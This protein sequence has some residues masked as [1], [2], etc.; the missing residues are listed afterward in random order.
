MQS[1]FED[2]SGKELRKLNEGSFNNK[3][4]VQNIAYMLMSFDSPDISGRSRTAS[5]EANKAAKRS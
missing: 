3:N 1:E 2:K 4:C 5:E